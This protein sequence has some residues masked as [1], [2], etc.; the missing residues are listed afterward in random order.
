VHVVTACIGSGE[1]LHFLNSIFYNVMTCSV[2]VACAIMYIA[3]TH[4]SILQNCYCSI[5]ET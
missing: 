4:V 3:R 1:G 2:P 5:L